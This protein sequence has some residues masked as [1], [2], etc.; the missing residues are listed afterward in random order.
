MFVMLTCKVVLWD[1]VE[2]VRA[3]DGVS[4]AWLVI[5]S[6]VSWTGCVPLA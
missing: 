1:S 6:V 4:V 5:D 3:E 2:L